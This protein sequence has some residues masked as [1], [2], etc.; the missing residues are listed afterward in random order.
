MIQEKFANRMRLVKPSAIRELLKYASDPE[1]ISFGGGFP[2]PDLFPLE[3]L[4]KVFSNV[5][6]QQGKQALQY[7][8]T[9]GL[10]ALRE[11]LALRMQRAGVADCAPDDILI[12]QGGQQGLDLVAKMF[13]DKG[14]VIA[15][16]SPT[17]L[18][19]L[20]AFNPYEPQYAP[21]PMDAYGMDMNAL[22]K[23]LQTT[24]N[25]KFIY[26]I[27]EFQNPTGR[28]MPLARRKQLMELANR[29]DV[30]ILEDSPYREIRYEGEAI[31]PIKS[32][33]TEGR[34]IHL[35][36]FSKILSP[37]LRVGW[38]HAEGEIT[39]K[40]CQLKMAADTQNSTVNMHAA[41]TFMDMYDLDAHIEKLASAYKKKKDLMLKTIAQELPAEVTYTDPEGGLFTWMTFPESINASTLM[42]EYLIPEAK[43]AY[44]PGDDFYPVNPET[45]HC[46]VNYSCMP[47][48]KIIV[49]I[50]KMG[51]VLK[52]LL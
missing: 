32:L 11:K 3:Q 44:V 33:D 8:S 20:V 50:T 10:P 34:V 48:E 47:E 46:R 42:K 39:K 40:L 51:E 30:V 24:K 26:T 19:A 15:V 22:E 31:P 49:G 4:E 5:I 25:I 7:T 1:V 21:I 27:P 41:N 38:V 37:G 13:I 29:Y 45:N 14:D 52:R 28:T 6:L 2:D 23:A 43:V 12:I 17:F 16:E 18:G 35:G 9:E 36:S